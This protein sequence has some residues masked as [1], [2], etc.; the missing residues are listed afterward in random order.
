M[1][2]R[3]RAASD[4][5]W[6]VVTKSGFPERAI[7]GFH[8]DEEDHW[9]AD[10]EYCHTRQVRHDPPWQNREWVLTLESR[11]ERIG[12]MY[13]DVRYAGFAGA[14]NRLN[15]SAK[16]AVIL[17]RASP[18]TPAFHGQAPASLP[19]N[20]NHRVVLCADRF[21]LAFVPV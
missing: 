8:Q 11:R 16:T 3:I 13:K 1:R 18:H 2:L 10:L 17:L 4:R 5:Q 21:R 6:C 7:I 14:K 15:L 19:Q 20:T 9:V 12:F